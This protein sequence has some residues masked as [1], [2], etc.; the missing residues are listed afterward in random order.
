MRVA[1]VAPAG[2][3]GEEVGVDAVFGGVEG[4]AGDLCAA[5]GDAAVGEVGEE[6]FAGV[7]A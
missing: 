7:G 2:R 5:E 6:V 4:D 3:E 1:A